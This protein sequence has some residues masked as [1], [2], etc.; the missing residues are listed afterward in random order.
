MRE[1]DVPF[2]THD[3]VIRRLG[4]ESKVVMVGYDHRMVSQYDAFVA[5]WN[6]LFHRRRR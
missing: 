1:S 5:R 4:G 2:L 3:S 6:E